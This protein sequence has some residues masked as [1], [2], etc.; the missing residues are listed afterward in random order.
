VSFLSSVVQIAVPHKPRSLSGAVGVPLPDNR[1]IPP[2]V[3]PR[4]EADLDGCEQLA[5]VVYELDG[6]PG[7]WPT[8]LRAFL[9]EP[10]A[11]AAWVAVADDEIVG[12]VALHPDSSD[13]A[14]S[15]AVSTTGLPLSSFGFV[16]RLFVAPTARRSGIGR[17]L[18][19]KAEEHARRR[20]LCPILDVVTLFQAAIEL[21]ETSGWTRAGKVVAHIPGDVTLEEFVY[22]APQAAI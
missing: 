1:P 12:H 21:Y 7:H 13:A 2:V 19:E 8:D 18:L 14:M 16:S 6:Y 4:R 11:I 15:L 20:G 5:Q 3:R 10:G 9:A 17:A 22:V